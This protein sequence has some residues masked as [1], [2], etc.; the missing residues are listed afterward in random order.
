MILRAAVPAQGIA[1]TLPGGQLPRLNLGSTELQVVVLLE[2]LEIPWD[3]RWSID[4]WIWFPEKRE[5]ISRFSPESGGLEKIHSIGEVH[6]SADKSGLHAL[7]LH[8]DFPE[9]PCVYGTIHTLRAR[10][11]SSG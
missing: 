8:P 6:Q 3:M 2:N 5:V 7:A 9:E 10:A 4:Q 1:G 11:G